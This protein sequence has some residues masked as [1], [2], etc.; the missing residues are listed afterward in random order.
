VLRTYQSFNTQAPLLANIGVCYTTELATQR[1]NGRNYN[2]QNLPRLDSAICILT[3]MTEQA[4]SCTVYSLLPDCT[5]SHIRGRKFSGIYMAWN[6]YKWWWKCLYARHEGVCESGVTAPPIPNRVTGWRWRG[7]FTLRP[8]YPRYALNGKLVG[9]RAGLDTLQKG[10][11]T[12]PNQTTVFGHHVHGLVT[13][14]PELSLFPLQ[15]IIEW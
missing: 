9:S 8:L 1:N 13:I 15:I 14:L 6:T 10:K 11:T 4:G 5:L 12:C 2:L 7:A 3:L